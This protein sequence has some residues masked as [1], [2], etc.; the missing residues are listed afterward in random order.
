MALKA[1]NR[2][3]NEDGKT[4]LDLAH[5][6]GASAELLEML[7]GAEKEMQL[8]DA[9]TEKAATEKAAEKPRESNEMMSPD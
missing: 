3:K 8:Y 9:K 5:E 4:P 6:K 2:I 7:Q 1:P